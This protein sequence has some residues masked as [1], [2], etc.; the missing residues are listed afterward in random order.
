MNTRSTRIA[1]LVVAL[2]L[3]GGCGGGT[4]QAGTASTPTPPPSGM[5]QTS[6]QIDTMELLS[7]AR[8]VS[9]SAAAYAV[10]DGALQ[11]TDTSDMSEPIS[12]GGG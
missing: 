11:F 2:S 10:N 5:G 8:Q 6:T 9:E 4:D 3:L 12:V 7:Q 1:S